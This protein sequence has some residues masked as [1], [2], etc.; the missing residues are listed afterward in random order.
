MQAN[1]LYWVDL[2]WA[3]HMESPALCHGA[4]VKLPWSGGFH[5]R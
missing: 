3:I 1:H 5:T 4:P 2:G